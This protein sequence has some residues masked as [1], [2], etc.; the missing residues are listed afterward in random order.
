MTENSSF[1]ADLDQVISEVTDLDPERLAEHLP[2][3][4]QAHQTLR[5]ALTQASTTPDS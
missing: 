1:S 5:A 3:F 2:V 4:E